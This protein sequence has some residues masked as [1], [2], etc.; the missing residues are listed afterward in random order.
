M[1]DNCRL[2][3]GPV[4]VRTILIS[5]LLLAAA[6]P[7]LGEPSTGLRVVDKPGEPAAKIICKRELKTGTLA[8]YQKICLTKAGWDRY[9]AQSRSE[10][11]DLQGTRGSTSGK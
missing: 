7:A 10:W 9:R 8:T 6:A 11:S 1:S 2:L 3:E 4:M 5:A